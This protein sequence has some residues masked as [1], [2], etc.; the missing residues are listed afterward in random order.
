MYFI[1]EAIKE[2]KGYT[3]RVV[4]GPSLGFRRIYA[5]FHSH[6]WSISIC[7]RQLNDIALHGGRFVH[8]KAT[9]RMS[10]RERADGRKRAMTNITFVLW[11]M[12]LLL[13]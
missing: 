10:N 3:R 2:T 5:R 4:V 9:R 12:N 13:S 6:S 1:R 8:Q 11:T 7:C